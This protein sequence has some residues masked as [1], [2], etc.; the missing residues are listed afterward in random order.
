MIET[1]S[2][3]F[4][5]VVED[6]DPD[7]LLTMLEESEL[8]S[9]TAERRKLRYALAWARLHP[10]TTE[11]DAATWGDLGG[12]DRDYDLRMHDFQKEFL[13]GDSLCRAV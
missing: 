6:L 10:A 7:R 9:R 12:R 4:P 5:V 11:E 2:G 8:Q 13:A 1:D 3:G